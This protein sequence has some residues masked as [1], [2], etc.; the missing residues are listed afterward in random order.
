MAANVNINRYAMRTKMIR[1]HVPMKW[2][3][4]IAEI[5]DGFRKKYKYYE[6]NFI[7]LSCQNP[8]IAILGELI[9]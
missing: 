7:S 2:I 6:S 1:T 8:R 3:R 5:T 9:L 4:A